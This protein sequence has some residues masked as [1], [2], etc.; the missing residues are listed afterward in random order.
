MSS[1]TGMI[2][3]ALNGAVLVTIAIPTFNRLDYLK[4]AVAS[5]LAQTYER[6]EVL[7]G[8]DGTTEAI[9]EWCQ[10]LASREARVRYQRNE[11]NLGLAGNWNALVDAARGR[12]LV[13]IG[14]DDRLL[15]DFVEKL[16]SII[17]LSAAQVAGLA[18]SPAGSRSR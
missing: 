4:E 17:Q 7:I 5:A 12:F 16:V 13:I 15:P 2:Y 6:I 14:D 11:K 8:D 3:E 1:K 9:R 18:T 10:S